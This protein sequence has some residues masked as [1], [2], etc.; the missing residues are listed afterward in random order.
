MAPSSPE[1]T[2]R[3]GAEN[4]PTKDGLGEPSAKRQRRDPDEN[5]TS[6]TSLAKLP[7]SANHF[8]DRGRTGGKQ[9]V[10]RAAYARSSV[11]RNGRC[12]ACANSAVTPAKLPA[13][14][15]TAADAIVTENP[16]DINHTLPRA[17]SVEASGDFLQI[18]PHRASADTVLQWGIFEGKYSANFLIGALFNPGHND[19][20]LCTEATSSSSGDVI[21]NASGLTHLEEEK[22]PGLIDR[23]LQNVHT[24]NPILD[25]EALVKHGRRCADQGIGWDGR[26]C[27]VLM[28]CA[29]GAV[30]KPFD[31]S[32]LPMSMAISPVSETGPTSASATS[33]KL[34]AKELQ[35]G[36][37]C[38]TMACRRLGSLKYSMLGAQCHF[39]AGVYLMYTL[40]PMLSWHYFL[41]ASIFCQMYL[42]M[43][44]GLSGNFTEVLGDSYQ[45]S[46]S[47]DHLFP[48]PPSPVTT[49]QQGT[50]S[51]ASAYGESGLIVDGATELRQ[52][53]VRLCNEEESWY[54]YL[55]EIA[56]R[57]IGNRI[58]NTFFRQDKS[59]W[60][61][62]KPLLR[63][64]QEF[65][66]QVLSWSA[67]LPP[68]MQRYETT[69]IIRAPDSTLRGAGSHVSRELSWAIDNR[70]L[71]MQTWLY[72]PF[73]Y[74]LIHAGSGCMI[75]PAGIAAG[76][77]Q[78]PRI[79]SL[80][81][82]FSPP[83]IGASPGSA[84]SIPGTSPLNADD[85]A[86]LHSLVSS[87]IEC[88]IRTI[89][90]RARGHR[91]HGLWYDL[92]SIMCASLVLLAV[93]KSGNADWIPGGTAT[94][95]G[96]P[97]LLSGYWTG[98]VAPIGGKIA[99]ALSQFDFW[100]GESPDLLRYKEVLEA[101]VRDVRGS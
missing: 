2:T 99:K 25:V 87:G 40:R 13:R 74:Y 4:A 17:A 65:E 10:N 27:L 21:T 3:R 55:T 80:L 49:D 37:C 85:L 39:F 91:H 51:S 52:H 29:L 38:F 18:P 81:N 11:T 61:N 15:R 19:V 6:G 97:P 12:A 7:A 76:T 58:V 35:Q 16:R 30:A 67:H 82:P 83:E 22:I 93:V 53:V 90:V 70:L 14:I 72:Q 86:V 34:Y 28:A 54:Y 94:L 75:E 96:E 59:S 32:S 92:R 44:H 78:P 31:R 71:E 24:K 88:L 9:L 79:S 43:T 64:A 84:A 48:S 68:A 41:H 36:D 73:L 42:K 50:A 8:D 26:S 46:T 98:T 57:R 45:R 60:L 100:A 47:I 95:W 101:V 56:L 77:G 1:S 5:P 33:S 66:A 89:D 69:S 63:M 20:S 62:V 23:F